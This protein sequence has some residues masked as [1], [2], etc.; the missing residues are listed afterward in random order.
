MSIFRRIFR[1]AQAEGH[2]VVDQFEDPIKMTEQGV[3][4]LKKNL[5]EAMASLAQVKSVA[6]RLDKDAEDQRRLAADYERK[7]MLL[8]Q[9][10]QGGGL[11]ATEAERLATSA[12]EQKEAASQRAASIRKDHETQKN[13]ADQLQ[14]KVEKLRRDISRY[15]NELITLRARARTAQSMAKINKQIAGVDT[16]STVA[17]LEKMKERVTEQE[18]LAA[19]YGELADVGKSVEQEIEEALELPASST[20]SDSLA[21]LKKKMGIAS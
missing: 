19:A 5:Q 4:D 9:K 10:M 20:A 7:A 21:E 17:M 1:V 13:A 18:S 11:D 14:T 16:T 15:E 12:L 8:L 6:I 2:A 3:R